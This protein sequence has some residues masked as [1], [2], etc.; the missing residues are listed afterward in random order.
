MATENKCSIIPNHCVLKHCSSI[1][2]I[3]FFFHLFLSDCISNPVFQF[4]QKI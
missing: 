4:K 3:C 1:H 2:F